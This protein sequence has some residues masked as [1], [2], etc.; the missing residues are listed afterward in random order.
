MSTL[1]DKI[2]ELIEVGN[3]RGF[4]QGADAQDS[5][6]EGMSLQNGGTTLLREH[7]EMTVNS[8]VG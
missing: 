8:S 1:N 4:V 7:E 6:L 2:K 5:P 3:L